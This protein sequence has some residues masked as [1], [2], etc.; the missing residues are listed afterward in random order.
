MKDA[1]GIEAR[2]FSIGPQWDAGFSA[3]RASRDSEIQSIRADLEYIVEHSFDRMIKERAV[4]ALNKCLS[5]AD[6]VY[7]QQEGKSE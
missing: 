1:K 4:A 6:A 5:R 3:G 7:V 2:P